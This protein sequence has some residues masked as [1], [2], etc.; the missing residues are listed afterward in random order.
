VAPTAVQ[1]TWN[2][3]D[4]SLAALAG[5]ITF[6]PVA[7]LTEGAAAVPVTI[8]DS[9]A[10]LVIEPA[11]VTRQ[12]SAGVVESLADPAVTLTA[13]RDPALAVTQAAGGHPPPVPAPVMGAG[14]PCM[15]R[16]EG[17]PEPS[18]HPVTLTRSTR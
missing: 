16:R 2:V 8:T 4:A 17:R 10:M 18:Q 6:T 5:G 9:A 15:R 11:G 3:E 13:P 7:V 1:V 12:L 14:A